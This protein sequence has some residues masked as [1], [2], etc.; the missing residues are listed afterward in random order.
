[1]EL[2]PKYDP[3]NVRNYFGKLF[4]TENGSHYGITK[5]GKFTG[6]PS[7]EGADIKLIAGLSEELYHDARSCLNHSLKSIERLILKN[8][9]EIKPRLLLVASLTNEYAEERKRGGIVTSPI[10]EIV[11]MD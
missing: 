3:A 4:I 9:Q 11:D 10:K 1:M 7:I 5:N 2:K 8:G 6:R